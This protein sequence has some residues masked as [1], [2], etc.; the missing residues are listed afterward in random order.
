[1]KMNP[2]NLAQSFRKFKKSWYESRQYDIDESCAILRFI[3]FWN[4]GEVRMLFPDVL[5]QINIKG[6]GVVCGF[7]IPVS[8]FLLW[9]YDMTFKNLLMR[10]N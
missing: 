3:G 6:I 9:I 8:A 4:K 5:G 7:W 1:M 10:I 2:D